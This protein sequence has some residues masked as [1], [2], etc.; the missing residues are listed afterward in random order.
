MSELPEPL[1][2]RMRQQDAEPAI[3]VVRGFLGFKVADAESLDEIRADLRQT[4]QVST[5][6]LR[7]ELAAFEAVL[8]DPP[9]VPGALARMVAWEGN[10]VLEDESDVGAA[11]FLGELAQILRDV[12]AEAG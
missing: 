12:L 8:A 9:A 11:R 5:R 3:D 4:A 6:K 1:Q 7:R 2:A 10:W